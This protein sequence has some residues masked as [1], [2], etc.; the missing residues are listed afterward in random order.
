[1]LDGEVVVDGVSHL[2]TQRHAADHGLEGDGGVAIV[3]IVLNIGGAEGIVAIV[4]AVNAVLD[5]EE[6]AELVVEAFELVVE[7]AEREEGR[8]TVVLPEV[9]L[10]VDGEA[11]VVDFAVFAAI[12]DVVAGVEGEG[13][14]VAH[15]GGIVAVGEDIDVAGLELSA[16]GEGVFPLA[17]RV[18]GKGGKEDD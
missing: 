13:A 11:F 8:P 3:G 18:G 4:V 14:V 5:A 1:M 7:V 9:A 17:L 6:G 15:H 12:D 10:D 2:E 16:E